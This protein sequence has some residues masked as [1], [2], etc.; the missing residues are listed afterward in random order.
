MQ[1]GLIEH[2]WKEQFGELPTENYLTLFATTFTADEGE[3]K[4]WLG[5]DSL[6]HMRHSVLDGK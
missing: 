6:S 4:F 5:T 1:R 2:I 3:T